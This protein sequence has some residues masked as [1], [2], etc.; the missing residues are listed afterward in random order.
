MAVL[1]PAINGCRSR[2]TTGEK[3]FADRLE[4]KLEDDYCCWYDVPIGRRNAHPDFIILHPRRGLLILEVKDW[5]LETIQSITKQDVT[6]YA[7]TGIKTDV[8]P[9]EKARQYAHAVV[10]ML[11]NDTQLTFASGKHAGNLV[12][13]WTYGVVLANITRKQFEQDSDLAQVIEPSR[14]ICKDEITE[15]T[16]A[17][18]FQLQLWN[19]FT[20]KFQGMLSLPRINRIR[21]HM[22]PEIRIAPAQAKL[23]DDSDP[24]AV[25]HAQVLRVMDMQQEQLARSLGEGHRI[26]HGVA[27]SGKTL[28][29]GYRAEYLAKGATKPA[30]IL[31][32]N[33]ELK[34][35]LAAVMERKGLQERVHVCNFHA[36]CYAQLK[37]YNQTLPARS[38]GEAY[39]AELVERV[40]R[41]VDRKQI[42]AGQYHSVLID[43]G[44]DFKP[45]WL[46]LVVQMVD[47]ETNS[48]L[49]LY[50]DAQS[51]YQRKGSSKFTFSSVGIKA[52]GRT[53]ILKINYRN[54]TQILA[55]SAS[56]AEDLLKPREAED[57]EIPLAC[58]LGSGGNGPVPQVVKLPTL[59]NEAEFLAECLLRADEAGTSWKEMAILCP[60][61]DVI[62]EVASVFSLR[63]IPVDVRYKRKTSTPI[64][65]EAVQLLTM[66]SSK[67]LEFPL[68]GIAGFGAVPKEAN[69]VED[70]RLLYVALTRATH[71]LIV[72]YGTDS[73][74]GDRLAEISARLASDRGLKKTTTI[75]ATEQKACA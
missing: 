34:N 41:G 33:K 66:H 65:K 35:K 16:D 20:L 8:N 49:V 15:S 25:T 67:G 19:M 75:G 56:F 40:I 10:D 36:W 57:D 14:A 46:K 60:T 62:D 51:I 64:S 42:P 2:M 59:R 44:H 72:T 63:G 37:T 53:T 26:I 48:L 70:A 52:Q 68:V 3:R 61:R 43:E 4:D 69:P 32:Y 18:Q 47:P 1:I 30:L 55:L 31:C 9:L 17:A 73:P 54:T 27:G 24:D 7:N 29:L 39:S 58:P 45:E 12:F 22:F 11:K 28:I 38:G 50:D 21:W 71:Q 74:L 5:K 13:P 6:L 23:F